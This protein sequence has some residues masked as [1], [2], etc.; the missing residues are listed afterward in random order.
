MTN[1]SENV[2]A[3]QDHD[4]RF[5]E[6]YAAQSSTAEAAE[7]AG[8]IR[9]LILRSRQSCSAPI[10]GLEIADIGCNAGTQSLAWLEKGHRVHGV[11]V[12]R[13]LIALAQRRT[14]GFGDRACFDVGDATAL[15]WPDARFDVCLL[16][17]LLEHVRDWEACLRDAIRILRPGGTIFLSTTNVLCP[18]QQEFALPMYSWYPRP[19]KRYFLDKSM[20]T[21]PDLANFAKFPAFH[22]FSPYELKGYLEGRGLEVRDRF[23]LIDE[24][25]RSGLARAVIRVLKRW[26]VARYVGHVLTPSTVLIGQRGE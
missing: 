18:V 20:T 5:V 19:V 8:R 4:R 1:E 9:D 11:D 17:E 3:A 23:D 14:S 15:P 2:A 25:G 12:S 7:R 16:P 22:W 24:A 6:Y 10:E 13:D 21:R 26:R